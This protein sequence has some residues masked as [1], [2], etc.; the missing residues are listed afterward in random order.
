MTDLHM[1]QV[2]RVSEQGEQAPWPHRNTMVLFRSMQMEQRNRSS[3]SW[4]LASRA[5]KS[6]SDFGPESFGEFGQI[7]FEMRVSHSMHFFIRLEQSPQT[8]RW[9]QGSNVTRGNDSQ[10]ILHSNGLGGRRSAG[11]NALAAA[12]G[13]VGALAAGVL[14]CLAGFSCATVSSKNAFARGSK[15]WSIGV[16]PRRFFGVNF[17]PL[18]TRNVAMAMAWTNFRGTPNFS[19]LSASSKVNGAVSADRGTGGSPSRLRA[20]WSDVSPSTSSL[21]ISRLHVDASYRESI[22]STTA[23]WPWWTAECRAVCP[24][25]SAISGRAL[26][27]SR[28]SLTQ[29]TWPFKLAKSRGENPSSFFTSTRWRALKIV[30]KIQG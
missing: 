4:T 12:T 30:K 24:R 11:S 16:C 2:F 19:A 20:I 22:V 1:W 27:S 21:L 8:I 23:A 26:P 28:S 13:E 3:K 10:Q 7:L 29:G 14:C 5:C 15:T 25:L 6:R 17:P 9:P 18:T